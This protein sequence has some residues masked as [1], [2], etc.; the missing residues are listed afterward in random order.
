MPQS[1]TRRFRT[2]STMVVQIAFAAPRVIAH[3]TLRLAMAGPLLSER[4]RKEFTLMSS[5][6]AIAF[7]ESWGGMA[8]HLL[9]VNQRMTM[10]LLS[11]WR[12]LSLKNKP[13]TVLLPQMQTAALE[14]LDKGV[15]PLHR[16]TTAN[17]RRLSKTRLRQ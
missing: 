13:A 12:L 3:R 1:P 7:T 11:P 17:A 4:D 15:R 16:G 6:K 9:R 14:V 2:L 5:E 10:S 8:I